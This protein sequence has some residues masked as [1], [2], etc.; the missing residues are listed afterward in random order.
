MFWLISFVFVRKVKKGG[1]TKQKHHVRS[2]AEPSK[3]RKNLYIR[4]QRNYDVAKGVIL[5][6]FHI[7]TNSLVSIYI[8]RILVVCWFL[9]LICLSFYILRMGY[10]MASPGQMFIFDIT[11][12]SGPEYCTI[13]F[14]FVLFRT[15]NWMSKFQWLVVFSLLEWT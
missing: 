5:T 9:E 10:V 7:Y 8:R 2:K 13:Q 4:K 14:T 3:T 12:N 1:W 15:F 11:I 6:C